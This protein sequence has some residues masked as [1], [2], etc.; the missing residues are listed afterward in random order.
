MQNAERIV[1]FSIVA[2]VVIQNLFICGYLIRELGRVRGI[3]SVLASNIPIVN[4]E[5]EKK[6]K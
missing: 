6:H 3:E 5:V 1:L 4:M 2:L